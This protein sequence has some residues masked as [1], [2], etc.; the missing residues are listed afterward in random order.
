[1]KSRKWQF[2]LWGILFM[3]ACIA[4]FLAGYRY[5]GDVRDQQVATS[6][7]TVVNYDVR[8]L[9]DGDSPKPIAAQL[10]QICDLVVDTIEPDSW[11]RNDRDIVPYPRNGSLV[12]RQSE[13]CH[14]EI[15]GLLEQLRRLKN[16]Q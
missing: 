14:E 1:M 8:E 12:I 3:M 6:T 16:R 11:H 2:G 7:I 5:G 10:S 9:L 15:R 13:S 4:G